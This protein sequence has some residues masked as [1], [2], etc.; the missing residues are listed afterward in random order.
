MMAFLKDSF[1]LFIPG[2]LRPR[3][4]YTCAIKS[5]SSSPDMAGIRLSARSFRF[6][7]SFF[8]VLGEPFFCGDSNQFIRPPGDIAWQHIVHGGAQDVL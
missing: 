7:S 8:M 6:H 4:H 1:S 3:R 2:Y 5:L